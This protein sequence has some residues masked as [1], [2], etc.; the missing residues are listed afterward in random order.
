MNGIVGVITGKDAR[1]PHHGG[2]S[3]L[4]P[5]AGPPKGDPFRRKD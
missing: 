2:S 1:G 5:M 4:Q 3:K